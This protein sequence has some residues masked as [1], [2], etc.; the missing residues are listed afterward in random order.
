MLFLQKFLS[1]AGVIC[2]FALTAQ[3]HAD[4]KALPWDNRVVQ[5]TLDNGFRYYLFDSRQEKDAPKGLTLANLVVLSGAIDEEENQLGVAH[6]VEHMVF[7]ES[8]ELPHGVR[9][10]F[11][12]MGLSK[13]VILMP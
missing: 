13:V 8:D 12:D 11:T 7:H 2:L 4:D 9:K 10:A 5:G 6:M 3:V 1:I